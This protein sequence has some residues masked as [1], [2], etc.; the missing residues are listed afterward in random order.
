[1]CVD[2]QKIGQ[3][4]VHDRKAEK[5]YP[6]S[7]YS[8]C[9]GDPINYIDPDGNV[10]IFINGMHTGDGGKPEY[11]GGIDSK[12]QDIAKDH[13]ALYY[14]GATGGNSGLPDNL[15]PQTRQAPGFAAGMANASEIISN[16]KDGETIKF[17]THSMGAAYAKGFIEGMRTYG[18]QNDIDVLV[19]IRVEI[20]FAPYQP[21]KQKGIDGI[22]TIVVQHFCD[23][24]ALPLEMT[25][26]QRFIT[27]ENAPQTFFNLFKEHSIK[28]F[29]DDLENVKLYLR[30][31]LAPSK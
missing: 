19:K 24:I 21:T 25:N 31:N 14:D 8:Y 11:W 23:G 16:L 27:H 6:L 5:Y 29:L 7:I 17:V 1:M 15:N 26:A 9:G 30:D 13:K 10:I 4:G 2:E 3:W 20:D 18:E 12:I 28:S 22:K